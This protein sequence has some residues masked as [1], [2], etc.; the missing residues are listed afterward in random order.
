[1]AKVV[2]EEL[3]DFTIAPIPAVGY[4]I[5]YDLDGVLKQKDR[6][7]FCISNGKDFIFT[8]NIEEGV[9]LIA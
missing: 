3:I 6:F 2:F 7:N 1:M 8:K 5:G 4:L 9:A